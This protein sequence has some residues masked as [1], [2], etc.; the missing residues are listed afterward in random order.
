MLR[1]YLRSLAQA[2]GK[3]IT[4]RTRRNERP[5]V[6]SLFHF[7]RKQHFVPRGLV[8]E[9]AEIE[10]PKMESVETGV[11][12]PDQLRAVLSAA[13]DDIRPA[14]AIGAFC[15]LRTAELARLDRSEVKLGERVIV[16]GE[17]KAKTA[18]RRIVPI[19]DKCMAW[20]APRSRRKGR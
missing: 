19:A 20:L 14:L 1:D 7:A 4:N 12:T 11:F 5:I 18:A 15:G 9:I 13:P 6:T 8:D 10:A 17:D 3:D 2:N 16:I